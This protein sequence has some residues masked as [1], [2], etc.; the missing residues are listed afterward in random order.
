MEK[1]RGGGPGMRL[2][3]W[4][5]Y[6]AGSV[7]RLLEAPYHIEHPPRVRGNLFGLV[8]GAHPVCSHLRKPCFPLIPYETDFPRAGVKQTIFSST[9]PTHHRHD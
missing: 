1:E 8:Y 5:R 2:T 9:Y 3:V 6:Q 7:W 4:F